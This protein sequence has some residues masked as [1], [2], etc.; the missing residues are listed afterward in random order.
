MTDPYDDDRAPRPPMGPPFWI[1]LGF[2]LVCVLAGLAL[3]KLGPGL[4]PPR[5]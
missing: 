4:F 5:H 1:A 2:G 3:A